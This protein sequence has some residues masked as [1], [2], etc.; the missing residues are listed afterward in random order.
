VKADLRLPVLELLPDGSC[1]S[2]V[3]RPALHDKARNKLIAA[4]HAGE[5][6]S[7]S[8]VQLLLLACGQALPLLD[9]AAVTAVTRA[10]VDACAVADILQ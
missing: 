3:A 10:E 6:S 1:L 5:Y 2:V 7:C 4:A 9:S 8:S